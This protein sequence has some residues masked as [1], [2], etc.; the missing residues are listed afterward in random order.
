VNPKCIKAYYRSSLALLALER[1]K[2][3]LDCCM[4]CLAIDPENSSI[5][6][7][8]QRARNLNE[9]QDQK[10]AAEEDRKKRE[11]QKR[12]ALSAALKVR[13]TCAGLYENVVVGPLLTKPIVVTKYNRSPSRCSERSAARPRTFTVRGRRALSPCAFPLPSAR[14]VRHHFCLLRTQPFH[15][16]S[17]SNVSSRGCK[18][19]L[20]HHWGVYQ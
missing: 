18:A 2:E 1:A 3:A 9:W 12:N 7:V 19:E 11:E 20:G 17:P 4:R 6:G 8:M 13:Q 16:T 5:K 14:A 15:R 10:A